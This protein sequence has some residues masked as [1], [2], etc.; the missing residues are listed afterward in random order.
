MIN[1]GIIEDNQAT[2]EAFEAHFGKL[3]NIQLLLSE[4]SADVF[5]KKA[6]KLDESLNIIFLDI[7]LNGESG[8]D[9]IPLL[10]K[11]ISDAE[12][13]M[14]TAL[15]DSESLI[16]AM[17]SGASG[18]LIKT[19]NL[20]EIES[21]INVILDGGAVIS[22]MMAKKLLLYFIPEPDSENTS[23]TL[24]P[25]EVQVLSLLRMGMSYEATAAKLRMKIDTL[26]YYIKNIYKKLNVKNKTEAIN[27]VFQ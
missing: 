20:S 15:E 22:P 8:I 6:K 18:Y 25:I 27:K 7:D 5:I 24:K 21:Q 26:R 14:F 4:S 9:A 2:R 12:I 23:E 17:S 10:K 16:K 13:I 1:I 3:N 19:A 11:H